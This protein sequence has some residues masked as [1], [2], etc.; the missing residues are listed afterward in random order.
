MMMRMRSCRNLFLVTLVTSL[1]LG[2]SVIGCGGDDKQVKAPDGTQAQGPAGQPAGANTE[3]Q[4]QVGVVSEPDVKSSLGGGAL[5][6]YNQ[7]FQA[8]TAG[9]LPAAK[10]LFKEAAE[11]D[12]K[13]P[14]PEYSLGVVLERM[15]DNAGAQQAFRA[16]FNIQPDYELAIGAYAL[17]LAAK[18]SVSEADTFLS[19]KKAKMPT[20]PRIAT[21]L[22]EV[23]SLAGDHGTA[24]QLAQD[25]LRMNPD[26]KEAMVAIARDHYRARKL[27]LSRYAVQAILDGTG[28]ANP[29]RDKDNAEASLLR[30]LIEREYGRR[31]VAFAALEVA[32]KRRPDMVEAQILLGSMR[33]EAGNASDALPVLEDAV[34]FGPS[35]ALAHLN[36]GDCYRLLGRVPEARREFDTAKSLD[37]SISQVHYDVG[38]L[39]LFAPSISGMNAQ[40]QVGMAITEFEKFKTMKTKGVGDDVDDL[41]S[42]AKTK[43]SELKSAAAAPPAAAPAEAAPKSTAAPAPSASGAK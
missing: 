16:A 10:K 24:Q 25:A 28:D 6:S 42:R 18:G 37:S 5:E 34:K 20:S 33:L 22:A 14:A 23:K 35:N 13:S 7:G 43:Q 11:K 39:F 8:W 17:S 32:A 29:P 31:A 9:D 3:G 1:A 41:I 40:D 12:R 27:E 4:G 36:L 38:L 15:G 19:D 26:F 30:G 21:Y 2:T